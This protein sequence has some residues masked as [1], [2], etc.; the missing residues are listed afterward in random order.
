MSA[1]TSYYIDTTDIQ[2]EYNIGVQRI[3]GLLEMPQRKKPT[4][5][6]WLDEDGAEAFLE[7]SDITWQPRDIVLHCHMN[8]ATIGQFYD[9][10]SAL[11]SEI[12][13]EGMHD[14]TLKH[15]YPIYRVYYR[16]GSP[17][18][19]MSK[20]NSQNNIGQFKL[21]FRE[22][23]PKHPAVWR[24]LVGHWMLDED[25]EVLGSTVITNGT[26]TTDTAWT[27]SASWTIT[28][29]KA[30]CDGAQTVPT[31]L[32]QAVTLVTN[33]TFR[34]DSVISTYTA[35]TLRAY[36][37]GGTTVIGQARVGN[38]SYTE[39]LDADTNSRLN[40]IGN[41]LFQ[42]KL[43]NVVLKAVS[44]TDLSIQANNASLMRFSAGTIYATDR[45]SVAGEALNFD[46]VGYYVDTGQTFQSTFRDSFS[47]TM[48]VKPD[49]GQPA[50]NEDFCGSELGATD[51]VGVRLN[52]SGKI[53]FI[54]ESDNDRIIAQTNVAQFSNGAGSWSHVVCVANNITSKLEVYFNGVKKTL[55]STNN[56]SLTGIT[57]GDFTTTV[58]LVIG[59]TNDDGTPDT[60]FAGDIQDVRIYDRA[61]SQEEIKVLYHTYS[62]G[63]LDI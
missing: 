31:T 16:D 21:P 36:L 59:A 61:I 12:L 3:T 10:L 9:R 25:G 55:D 62:D 20:W 22:P 34:L 50:S 8:A 32:Y 63:S 33:Q 48:W 53:S 56:G 47:I 28:S 46:G 37:T 2:T 6:S 23:V 1:H 41:S 45:N 29:G 27:K 26:F 19:R 30:V 60:F 51:I 4:E 13:S 54:Y 35:G 43:D 15:F 11:K 57:M 42:A 52:T 40:F 49:D 7:E 58:N 18:D 5:Y 38:G 14:L 44:A 17:F 24:S 39:Y